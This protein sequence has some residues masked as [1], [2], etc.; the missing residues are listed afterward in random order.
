MFFSTDSITVNKISG[1]WECFS[2]HLKI[3]P[4]DKLVLIMT[5]RQFYTTNVYVLSYFKISITYLLRMDIIIFIL[6]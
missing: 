1:V 5:P 3:H 2:N 4:N 6:T